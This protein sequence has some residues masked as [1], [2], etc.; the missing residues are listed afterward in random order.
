MSEVY[1]QQFRDDMIESRKGQEMKVKLGLL[2]AAITADPTNPRIGD[3]IMYLKAAGVT[4]DKNMIAHLREILASGGATAITHLL[5]GNSYFDQKDRK[6][7][8]AIN[9]WQLAMGQDPNMVL[10]LNNL[11]VAMSYL[12][13]PKIDEGLKLI[14]RA[15]ELTNGNAEFYDSRGEI[16]DRA[17][18]Y[19][20]AIVDFEKALVRD[21]YRLATREKLYQSYKSAGLE[22][23]AEAQLT[24][25]GKIRD[26]FTARGI[27][28]D[29]MMLKPQVEPEA[30]KSKEQK[31]EKPPVDPKVLEKELDFLNE[32]KP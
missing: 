11:A 17:G 5:L 14:D 21:P 3:D 26:Q 32:K 8:K 28:V 18:R 31:P 20:E 24:A 9:H 7:D 1:R 30:D 22:D 13:P 4:V 16:L 15:I 10:A 25:I 29:A 27:N 6:I 19:E 23:L 2:N 12:D